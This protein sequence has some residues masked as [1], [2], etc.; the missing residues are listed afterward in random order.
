MRDPLSHKYIRG[1]GIEIGGL[2]FPLPVLPG[3]VVDY[4]DRAPLD[5]VQK[6]FHPDVKV[7]Q[8]TIIVDDAEK[9]EH[10]KKDS[11]DFVIANHVLEHCHNPIQAL[12]MWL[13]VL[14]VGGIVYMALPEKTFTFD[15]PRAVTTIDHLLKDFYEGPAVRDHEHYREWF[16]VI[17]KLSGDALELRVKHAVETYEN[18]HF[19]VWDGPA[20]D[21]LMSHPLISDS[22]DVVERVIHG[23][24]VIWILRRKS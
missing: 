2:H 16:S 15:K 23:A 21:Q 20:M 10:F 12:G 3:C 5:V 18:I 13:G 8:N 24:E 7:V 22:C 11:L 19:H 14:R 17:D 1:H 9:L 4:V 6:D